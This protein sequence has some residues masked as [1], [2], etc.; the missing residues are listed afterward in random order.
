M[1]TFRCPKSPAGSFT[2]A[3]PRVPFV[4]GGESCQCAPLSPTR[5]P[6][7]PSPAG[8]P[9]PG[10][11]SNLRLALQLGQP[12]RN[13][14]Q[15]GSGIRHCPQARSPGLPHH[16][17]PSPAPPAL[18]AARPAR[19]PL[20]VAERPLCGHRGHLPMRGQSH[21][22]GPG[23]SGPAA[24]G[25]QV[26]PGAPSPRLAPAPPPAPGLGALSCA[27]CS[28]PPRPALGLPPRRVAGRAS[29][30]PPR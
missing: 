4:S 1:S 9:S 27:A 24:R 14:K 20:S 21:G 22:Q 23:R 6:V 11:P 29:P 2:L 15:R 13:R 12:L 25:A 17:P 16:S 28:P 10:A 8:N 30:T 19:P 5:P 26:P 18:G 3:S 7:R